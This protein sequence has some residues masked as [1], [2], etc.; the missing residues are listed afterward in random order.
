MLEKIAKSQVL[1]IPSRRDFIKISGVGSAGFL[2]FGLPSESYARPPSATSL[3]AKIDGHIK[4]MRQEGRIENDEKTS[5]SV[6]DFTP[7]QK[8]V[9][10]NEEMPFQA[11]SMVKPLI[12][13]AFFHEVK[14]GRLKYDEISRVQLEASIQRSSNP[15]TNWI[16]RRIGGPERVQQILKENYGKILKNVSIAEDIPRDGKTY[17]NKASAR[18]YSRFLYALWNDRLPYSAELK[19]LMTLKKKNRIYDGTKVPE[20]AIV[21]DKTGSTGMLCGD[22]GILV[23]KDKRGKMYPYT[24]IGIIERDSRTNDY[25]KWIK[26]RGE[27]I[28]EISNIVYDYMKLKHKL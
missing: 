10:I 3:E 16:I 4:R 7:A 9:S 23:V 17:K 18:D 24:V 14:N 26:S 12:A 8:V 27:V 2:A 5:W 25:R 15:A 11:A 22:M 21:I 1:R 28:R 20:G 6:Y 13:L 19:E